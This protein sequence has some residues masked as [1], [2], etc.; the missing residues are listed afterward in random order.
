MAD[1]FDEKEKTVNLLLASGLIL[2]I[3][4]IVAAMGYFCFALGIVTPPGASDAPGRV[5]GGNATGTGIATPGKVIAE[6]VQE[7]EAVSDEIIFPG[8][9]DFSITNG[10]DYLDLK[11]DQANPVY[12]RFTINDAEG[13]TLYTS[14]DIHPGEGERWQVTSAFDPGTGKHD[15]TVIIDSFGESDGTQ[16]NG[17]STTFTVNMG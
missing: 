8:F 6:D 5:G 7:T 4:G 15:I 14:G 13:K 2:L 10:Q 11:N 17:V 12:F 3:C 1:Q 9:V 16:Y